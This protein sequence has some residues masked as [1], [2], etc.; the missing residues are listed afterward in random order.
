MLCVFFRNFFMLKPFVD[1]VVQSY[2]EI[3]S[4]VLGEANYICLILLFLSF[5]YLLTYML[6]VLI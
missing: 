1:I 4:I 6:F 2:T 3:K 5:V